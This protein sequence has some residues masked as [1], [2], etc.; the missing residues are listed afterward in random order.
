M[1]KYERIYLYNLSLRQNVHH[2]ENRII[3]PMAEQI[4][5]MK[6]LLSTPWKSKSFSPT[7]G[8]LCRKKE[9]YVYTKIQGHLFW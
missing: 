9:V 8:S 2:L 4:S 7:E 1:R 5:Q 3:L 6:S